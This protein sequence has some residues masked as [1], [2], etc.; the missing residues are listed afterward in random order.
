[1]IKA[2]KICEEKIPVPELGED[3]W[4]PKCMLYSIVCDEYK[5]VESETIRAGNFYL[6]YFPVYKNASIT[7]TKDENFKKLK[8]FEMDEL[9]HEQAVQWVKKLK[10][11]VTFS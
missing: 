2:C 7:Y 1:M 8:S 10:L 9:T 4:C 11:Y 5:L 3:W 6:H